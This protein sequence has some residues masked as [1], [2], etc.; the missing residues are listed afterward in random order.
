MQGPGFGTNFTLAC[1]YTMI[2]HFG[3]LEWAAHYGVDPSL[4][5]VWIGQ[6]ETEELMQVFR[7]A[8]QAV[9]DLP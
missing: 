9:E 4:V 5:R 6:E 3:E 1:P 2:A 8:M 7:N